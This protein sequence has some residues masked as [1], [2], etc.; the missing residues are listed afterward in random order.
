[1]LTRVWLLDVF[2]VISDSTH[3][4]DLA[5]N[6]VGTLVHS[7]DAEPIAW[8][9]TTPGY[10]HHARPSL[11]K[12]SGSDV[13]LVWDDGTG[14]S[15][16]QLIL[17]PAGLVVTADVPEPEALE[18][19]E[20]KIHCRSRSAAIVRAHG[21]ALTFITFWRF[22]DGEDFRITAVREQSMRAIEIDVSADSDADAERY[23]F[24]MLQEKIRREVL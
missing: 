12:T 9:T 8:P 4:Y 20:L 17:P 13:E 24:P 16:M 19:G 21:T 11:L 18:V 6:G 1:V 10:Q 23:R 22:R 7:Y 2:R 15:P 14:I 5:I 3:L